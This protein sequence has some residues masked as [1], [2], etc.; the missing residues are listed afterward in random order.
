MYLD[1]RERKLHDARKVVNAVFLVNERFVV[2]YV[3][4]TRSCLMSDNKNM[5]L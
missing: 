2:C 4:T 3:W 1:E 5:N